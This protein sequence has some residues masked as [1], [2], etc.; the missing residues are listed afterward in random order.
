MRRGA[1][2]KQ[3][4]QLPGLEARSRCVLNRLKDLLEFSPLSPA[5]GAKRRMRASGRRVAAIERGNGAPVAAA[6][7]Y[8]LAGIEGQLEIAGWFHL[9]AGDA[10]EI[11]QPGAV[12]AGEVE[13]R[14][15]AFR[16]RQRSPDQMIGAAGEAV[17]D[18]IPGR[19]D[20]DDIARLDADAR[21]AVA[22]PDHMR[23]GWR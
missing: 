23:R 4:V 12:D 21:R 2:S 5:T 11:G 20:P 8:G 3:F 16:R 6:A 10:V 18:V 7:L 22:Q 15:L 13:A 17:F 9:H 1:K 19:A 14:Q